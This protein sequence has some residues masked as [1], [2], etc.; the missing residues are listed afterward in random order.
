MR[1]SLAL[2][3]AL[4]LSATAVTAHADEV[5]KRAKV[6]E[7]LTVTKVDNNSQNLL[8]NVPMRVRTLASRQ[9]MV[10]AATSPEQKKMVGDYLEEMSKIAGSGPKWAELKPKV[11]D[12][13]MAAY[14]EADLDSI[15]GFFKSPAGQTYLTKSPDI[16]QKTLDMLQ[17]SIN[18]LAPQFEAATRAFQTNMQNTSPAG[19]PVAPAKAPTLGPPTLSSPK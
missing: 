13:Y 12:M 19:K 1:R 16:A 5:S 18:A 14:T 4:V 17:G 2:V 10:T 6:E 15:L 8:A 9:P 3:A 7:M 11:V